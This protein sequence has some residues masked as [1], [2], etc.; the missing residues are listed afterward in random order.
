MNGS[1]T[2][3][4][5]LSMPSTVVLRHYKE[6]IKKCSLSG[7]EEDPNFLF[8]SYPKS[9]P[10]GLEGTIV[11]T[12]D[13]PVLSKE[14]SDLDLLLVDGTWRYAA[15]MEEK[16][17]AKNP[18]LIKRSLPHNITTAY[19]RKQTGCFDPARGLASI[20]ALYVAHQLTGRPYENL[21]NRY[22]WKEEFLLKNPSLEAFS[23]FLDLRGI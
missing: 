15:Q 16:L 8:F 19:P 5:N 6:N 14:D 2:S 10:E 7:L 20:E 13:A 11:L 12:L 9:M 17:P 4:N 21:L 18:K 23:E 1:Y 3:L 22:Y